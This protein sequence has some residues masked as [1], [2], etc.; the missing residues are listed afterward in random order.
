MKSRMR[1]YRRAF[2]KRKALN[3]Q[4]ATLLTMASDSFT[5]AKAGLER[6]MVSC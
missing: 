6:F 3:R 4:R 5:E 2:A 1:A